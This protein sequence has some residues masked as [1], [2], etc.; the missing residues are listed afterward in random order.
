MAVTRLKPANEALFPKALQKL[1]TVFSSDRKSGERNLVRFSTV[2]ETTELKE[3]AAAKL[4][5]STTSELEKRI[6]DAYNVSHWDVRGVL[7]CF[8]FAIL[9]HVRAAH[10]IPASCDVRRVLWPGYTTDVAT[11]VAFP[12]AEKREIMRGRP[13]CVLPS[14][15]GAAWF[16]HGDVVVCVTKSGAPGRAEYAI[17]AAAVPALVLFLETLSSFGSSHESHI[18]NAEKRKAALL[19]KILLN[20]EVPSNHHLTL[21]AKVFA[22]QVLKSFQSGKKMKE[23]DD[24]RLKEFEAEILRLG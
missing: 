13:P 11:F 6:R 19:D 7:W 18:I 3:V 2:N 10:C 8:R 17:P 9:Q 23:R 21:Y 22:L 20:A 14:A 12:S 15:D 24:L 1:N 5:A 4:P 16:V